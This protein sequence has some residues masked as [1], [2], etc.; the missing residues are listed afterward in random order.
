M[1]GMSVAAMDVV[2]AYSPPRVAQMAREM[3]FRR[4]CGF[5]F[6][7]HD[8]DGRALDFNSEEM[9][10]R[11]A[12]LV[13]RD[14]PMLLI[15]NLM[16][17]VYSSM[18]QINHAR[19]SPEEVRSRFQYARKHLECSATLYQMQISAGRYFPHG[20][21]HTVSSWEET[22]IK[23]ILKQHNL[24]IVV[25]DQ[26]VYGFKSNDGDYEGPARKRA[27]FMSQKRQGQECTGISKRAL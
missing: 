20:H 18:N 23:P 9:C 3:G 4:G 15:G 26:C 17:T 6:T 12:R 19:M 22:C 14:R 1:A 13:L 2:G 24:I 7:T 27:G 25:A 21:P 11:A 16:C 5:D 8:P 10:N